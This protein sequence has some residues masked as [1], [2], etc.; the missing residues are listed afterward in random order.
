[1]KGV[2]TRTGE[3]YA[4]IRS[5]ILRCSM[6]PGARFT[7]ARLAE[8]LGFTKAPVRE[9]LARLV[10]DGLIRSIPRHG[11]EVCPVTVG[12]VKDLFEL[13]LAVE[14]LATE[15]AAGR[16][17]Q[18]AL[19]RLEELGETV[20]DPSDAPEYAER[21]RELHLI[22]IRACGN[23]KLSAVV[24]RVLDE[25]ER[26][27]FMG[28]LHQGGERQL[29]DSHG[30]LVRALARSDGA[31]ARQIAYDTIRESQRA[32]VEAVFHSLAVQAAP[33]G[34]QS[35]RGTR[36]DA[37]E[38]VP[39]DEDFAATAADEAGDRRSM[40]H[41]ERRAD[42]KAVRDRRSGKGQDLAS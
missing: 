20:F 27:I 12:D 32:L 2:V 28:L 36:A 17:S 19:Q 10:Q 41:A 26:L 5:R 35:K 8:L 38:L 21:H 33:L 7:E 11:Y 39:P 23:R 30:D 3:A 25:S 1:M 9:A 34:L 16:I 29:G 13:R 31:A 37:L 18:A 4:R 6:A 22:V 42:R 40:H 14:P 24:E 15:L